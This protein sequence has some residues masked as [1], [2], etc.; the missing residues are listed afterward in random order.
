MRSVSRKV[1]ENAITLKIFPWNQLFSNFFSKNVDLTKKN[2][3]FSAKIVI[4]F[5]SA[6]PRFDFRDFMNIFTENQILL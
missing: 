1:L 4:V 3:Y 2:V 6:F 5:C